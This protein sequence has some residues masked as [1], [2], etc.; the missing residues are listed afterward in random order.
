M[1]VHLLLIFHTL[2]SI[3]HAIVCHTCPLDLNKLN[4]IVT[5]DNIPTNLNNCTTVN[6]GDICF[7]DL[8]WNQNPDTTDLGLSTQEPE[9]SALIQHSLITNVNL[10]NKD[11]D[12]IWTK[13]ISYTCSIDNCNSLLTLKR[14]LASLTFNDNFDDIKNLLR[15][16][17]PFDGNWC[18]LATNST[19]GDCNTGMSTSSCKECSFQG[20]NVERSLEYCSNCL[21]DDIGETFMLYEADFNMTDRTIADHWVLECRFPNCNTVQN[22]NMIREKVLSTFDFAKFLDNINT[23]SGL[24]SINKILFIFI[25]I[26]I[27]ILS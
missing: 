20:K 4:Y 23:A 7:I 2:Y 24:S 1:L 12:H 15:K 14:I 16:E 13:G 27:K 10:E 17:E 22:G 8:I 11:S 9:R 21:T 3:S 19:S 25:V 18:Q 5:M 26:F 6:T